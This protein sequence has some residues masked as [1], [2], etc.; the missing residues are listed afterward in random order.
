MVE[1]QTRG[2]RW[3]AGP[4]LLMAELCRAGITLRK[5]PIFHRLGSGIPGSG[6]RDWLRNDY[7]FIV[8]AT[9]GGELP[10]SDHKAMGEAPVVEADVRPTYRHPSGKRANGGR[11]SMKAGTSG[12]RVYHPPEKA[13]PGNVVSVRV[14]R[15]LGDE[16]CHENEAPFP[17]ALP[18]LFIRSFCRPGGVVGDPF[19]GSG[20]TGKVAVAWVR[21]FRGC[22]LRASQV[23]LTARRLA[24]VRH[25]SREQ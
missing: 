20:T 15:G 22:D 13:N 14:G 10:W 21:M 6:N 23:R 3:S 5:P 19:C 2:F 25:C 16:L 8:C 1:G 9:R 18:E 24:G 4:A 11:A 17:E 12:G 7:E